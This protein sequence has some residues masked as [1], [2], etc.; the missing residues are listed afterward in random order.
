MTV[1]DSLQEIADWL[2][3]T[4]C[5]K[6]AFKVPPKDV[7]AKIDDRYDYEKVHPHAFPLFV[8]AVERMP[9][10]V[11]S[12]MPSVCVQLIQGED[13]RII[14]ERE[15]AINLGISCWNPGVHSNDIHYPKGKAPEIPEKFKLGEDGWL[16][17]WNFAD[18]ILMKLESTSH[19]G[20]LELSMTK[21][22]TFGPYK[23]QDAIPDLYPFWFAWIQFSVKAAFLRNNGEEEQFL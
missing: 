8:P 9:P 22:I 1:V 7:K 14:G 13:N 16:D 6:Y 20:N 17:V 3:E 2:N 12:S 5:K 23:E 19:I 18:D 4:S 11:I 21:N 10:Q 15:L